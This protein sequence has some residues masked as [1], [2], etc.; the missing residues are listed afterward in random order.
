MKTGLIIYK[1]DLP[2][3]SDSVNADALAFDPVTSLRM[4]CSTKGHDAFQS[5]TN[6]ERS[7]AMAEGNLVSQV[8]PK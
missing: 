6:I 2:Y 5:V 4:N 8:T 3:F 1:K 7:D